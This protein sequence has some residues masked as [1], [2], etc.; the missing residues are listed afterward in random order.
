MAFDKMTLSSG[1]ITTVSSSAW[2]YEKRNLSVRVTNG[3][4]QLDRG[5]SSA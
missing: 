2:H 1:V 3:T 4:M 5:K